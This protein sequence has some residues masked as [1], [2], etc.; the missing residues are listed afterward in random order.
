MKKVLSIGVLTVSVCLF[1]GSGFAKEAKSGEVLFKEYCSACHPNGDNIINK[2]K[3]L[4]KK[5]LEASNIKTA[6]DLVKIMRKPGL[7][8]TRF[9][10][11]ILSDNDAKA[12]AEYILKAFN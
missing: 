11:E 2:K 1:A 3:T 12:I 4:H 10:P 8:M 6:D 7:G 9:N 5:D